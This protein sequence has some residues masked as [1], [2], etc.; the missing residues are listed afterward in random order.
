MLARSAALE[1]GAAIRSIGASD[2]VGEIFR[3]RLARCRPVCSK[4]KG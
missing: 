2:S 4:G 1:R 3:V